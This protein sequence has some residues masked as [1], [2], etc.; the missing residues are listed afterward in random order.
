MKKKNP[1]LFTTSPNDVIMGPI[2]NKLRSLNLLIWAIFHTIFWIKSSSLTSNDYC[3]TWKI[4][5]NIWESHDFL[6]FFW[7]LIT[8]SWTDAVSS[9]ISGWFSSEITVAAPAGTCGLQVS[10]V[11]K[12][13]LCSQAV[14]FLIEA[15]SVS[16]FFC[17]AGKGK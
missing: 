6:S 2:I 11:T 16:I 9:G 17:A 15:H 5:Q 14:Y 12:W 13:S 7:Q 3:L 4:S 10:P 1:C 8:I